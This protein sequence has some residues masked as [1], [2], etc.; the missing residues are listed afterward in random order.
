MMSE[1]VDAR[2]GR[3]FV[4]GHRVPVTALAALWQEG[5]DVETIHANY[6]SLA[7]AQILGG[8][9]FYLDHQAAID[10]QL[11]EDARAF[12]V[13]RA[14]QQAAN[15]ERYAEMDRRVAAIRAHKAATAS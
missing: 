2:D 5:A 1:Y 6:P 10:V 14:A 12:E 13:A 3:Y 11:V 15:T 9:A 4:R 8:L 7:M